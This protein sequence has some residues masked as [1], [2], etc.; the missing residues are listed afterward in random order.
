MFLFMFVKPPVILQNKSATEN[1]E[2]IDHILC[3]FIDLGSFAE[4]EEAIEKY[5]N[6]LRHIFQHA[7]PVVQSVLQEYPSNLDVKTEGRRFFY[8]YSRMTQFT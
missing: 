6:L 3:L 7:I 8:N 4:V 5:D 1:F 2:E